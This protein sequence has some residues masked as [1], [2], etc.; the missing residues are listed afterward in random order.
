MNTTIES[1][2]EW[3]LD[4]QEPLWLL[5]A[6][7]PVV[8]AWLYITRR[9]RLPQVTYKSQ[10]V[11]AATVAKRLDR[12]GRDR[13]DRELWRRHLPA[14]GILVCLLALAPL[15][16]RPTFAAQTV[17]ERSLITW[18]ID[19][20]QSMET[21]DVTNS[22][23]ES[24][25]RL[26]GV[27]ETLKL[28]IDQTPE[29]SFRQ[30]VTFS[31][32]EHV[33][34]HPLTR[35][36]DELSAQVA[37]LAEIELTH[38]TATEDGLATAVENCVRTSEL[39]EQYGIRVDNSGVADGELAMPCVVILLSDGECDNQ[40]FCTS[41][42]IDIAAEAKARGARV[43]TVSWGDPNG[44]RSQVFLPDAAA[45]QAIADAGG[46][47]HL[48]TADTVQLVALYN[49]VMNQVD[50][51]VVE[52]GMPMA[53]VWAIRAVFLALALAFGPSYVRNQSL[54]I[55]PRPKN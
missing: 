22:A 18:L 43:H 47:Q 48:E 39:V 7:I 9:R 25:S 14:F 1:I 34:T 11:E 3:F 55:R 23:G 30:M 32:E 4:L 20:S 37:A 54:V 10:V 44:D 38:S 49:E 8:L 33:V 17:E 50:S 53:I 35:S 45:M 31:D 36:S 28:T 21:V 42:S 52:H 29:N 2:F 26:E 41:E 19:T 16:A 40:P 46:G 27:I 13:G 6:V 51:G 5:T 15:T 12:K 24:V